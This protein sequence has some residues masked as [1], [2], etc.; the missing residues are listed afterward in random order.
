MLNAAKTCL[1]EVTGIGNGVVFMHALPTSTLV[2]YI[3][4]RGSVGAQSTIRCIVV[5][6]RPLPLPR[7]L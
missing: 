6:A 5:D 7:G 2:F 1:F 3:I 4:I